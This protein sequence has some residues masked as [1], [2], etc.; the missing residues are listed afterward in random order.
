MLCS[1][2][3]YLSYPLQFQIMLLCY[4]LNLGKKDIF[5]DLKSNLE[6]EDASF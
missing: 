3:I 6:N 5:Q 1:V 4:H 2:L